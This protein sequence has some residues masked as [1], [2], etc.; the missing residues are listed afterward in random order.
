[1]TWIWVCA[2]LLQ[3]PPATPSPTNTDPAR[4]A[5]TTTMDRNAV[6]Q[7]IKAALDRYREET[8]VKHEALGVAIEKGDL[9]LK[10][11]ILPQTI[12]WSVL[13]VLFG[14]NLLSI[15]GSIRHA[16][17]YVRQYLQKHLKDQA[18]DLFRYID[19]HR[20]EAAIPDKTRMLVLRAEYGASDMLGL[21][22]SWG[23]KDVQVQTAE[24][25]REN[26]EQKGTPQG[27][28]ADLILFD[29][30]PAEYIN[31]VMHLMPGRYFINYTTKHLDLKITDRVTPARSPMTLFNR[32]LETVKFLDRQ[33]PEQR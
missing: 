14:L 4:A 30:L 3:T 29:R 13:G 27:N 23:F 2:L 10:N 28:Q 8:K 6:D 26:L 24:T 11:K 19:N 20:Y 25:F 7:A 5:P 12:F 16:R 21:L 17:S 1:M 22:T 33:S 15:G 31:A 18:D 9:D 32:I